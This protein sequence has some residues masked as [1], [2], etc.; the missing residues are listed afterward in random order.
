MLDWKFKKWW[1]DNWL[2]KDI[3]MSNWWLI[4]D[5]LIIDWLMID[6]WLNG[7]WL[8]TKWWL[9]DDWS[10]ID[11]LLI[12]WWLIDD[13]YMIIW[14][15]IDDWLMIGWWSIDNWIMI[16]WWLIDDYKISLSKYWLCLVFQLY[17]GN[18][19]QGST[20]K[21]KA[22]QGNKVQQSMMHHSAIFSKQCIEWLGQVFLIKQRSLLIESW[23]NR[24]SCFK[25]SFCWYF[26]L[27]YIYIYTFFLCI[28]LH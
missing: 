12:D 3:L 4:D 24:Q 8:M 14:L 15:L 19:I 7:D 20:L 23:I 18:R 10:M 26:S 27:Y 13:W 16:N 28:T 1:I 2:V 6:W 17:W 9:I 21:Y 5:W 11:W 25:I 22:V